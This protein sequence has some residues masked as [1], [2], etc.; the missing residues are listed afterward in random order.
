MKIETVTGPVDTAE[1][2]AVLSHEH[3]FTLDRSFA[4]AFPDW[5]DAE[6]GLSR[7][8]ANVAKLKPLGLGAMIDA[9]AINLGRDIRLIRRASELAGIHII[10]TTGLYYQEAPG[11]IYGAEPDF[12]AKY[13][14]RELTEGI[15]GTDIKAGVVKCSS[16]LPYGIDLPNECMIRA[17]ARA[18]IATG[19]PVITHSNAGAKQGLRQQEIL[20]E[21]GVPLHRVAIGHSFSSGDVEYVA[22]LARAGSYVGC[23]QIGFEELVPSPRLAEM[24]AQLCR[25]GFEDHI[26]LSHDQATISDFGFA[27]A[28]IC[29]DFEHNPMIGDYSKVFTLMPGLL[30]QQGVT[31]AQIDKMLRHNPKRFLDGVPF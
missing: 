13:F 1:L 17:A 18:S 19:A 23:D 20:K 30:Q 12:L 10:A 24:I 15:Q 29:R 31:Q 14:I 3:V 28:P 8:A 6:E 26:L 9:T 22:D 4:F 5:F 27:F 7:F 2:G 25:M 11:I 21:E 16:D